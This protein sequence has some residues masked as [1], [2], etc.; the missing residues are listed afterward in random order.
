MAA[1]KTAPWPWP[2]EDL[3]SC[4]QEAGDILYVPDM[5]ARALIND[6]ESLGFVIETETG[7][8]EFSPNLEGK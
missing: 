7:A 6:E 3:Y 2:K 8:G 5:W 4:N 1:T